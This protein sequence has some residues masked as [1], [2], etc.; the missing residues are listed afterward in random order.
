MKRFNWIILGQLYGNNLGY[1]LSAEKNIYLYICLEVYFE[2]FL[3][4][5]ALTIRH[6][7]CK[8]SYKYNN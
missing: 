1:A 7:Q 3:S 6:L 8:L 4:L 2:V 5:I